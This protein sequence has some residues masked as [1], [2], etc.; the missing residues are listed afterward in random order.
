MEQTREMARA[1]G[2]T[3][4]GITLHA[5]SSIAGITIRKIATSVRRGDP[6]PAAAYA[7]E[8]GVAVKEQPNLKDLMEKMRSQPV[9]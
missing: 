6:G 7:P 3:D 4:D 5:E 2:F 8:P 1:L 9:R